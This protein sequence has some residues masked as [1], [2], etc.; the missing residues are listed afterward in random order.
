MSVT[1]GEVRVVNVYVVNGR[2]AG[3]LAAASAA[4]RCAAV[5]VDR[6]ECKPAPGEGERSDHGSLIITLAPDG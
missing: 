6:G 2:E 3:A 1:V 4:A 5:T